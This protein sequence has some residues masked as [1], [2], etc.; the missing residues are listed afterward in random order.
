MLDREPL[1]ALGGLTGPPQDDADGGLVARLRYQ[2]T[3]IAQAPDVMF[4]D[5]EIVA[6][7]GEQQRWADEH[8]AARWPP[9]VSPRYLFL[10]HRMNRNADRAYSYERVNAVLN[11]LARRLDIRDDAGSLVDFNRTHRFRHTRAT[12]PAQRRGP[13]A[14]R[15]ALPRPLCG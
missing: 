5:A 15:A 1:L 2:Q 4:V 8:L 6:I 14:C 13:A 9:G 11:K 7:I 3:K 10:A 12:S